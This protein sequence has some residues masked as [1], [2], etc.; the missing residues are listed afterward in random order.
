VARVALWLGASA[1]A[2]VVTAE[3][4]IHSV[5]YDQIVLEIRPL[6]AEA[7]VEDEADL[8]LEVSETAPT[9]VELHVL[10]PDPGR[11]SRLRLEATRRLSA[12]GQTVRIESELTPAG[13]GAATS[14]RKEIAF[15]SDTVTALFEVARDGDRVLTL[16]V[17]GELTHR[18]RY[19]AYPVVGA[20]VQFRV[21]VEWIEQGRAVTLET[22]RLNT[23]VGQS[24]GYSFRL[25]EIGEAEAASVRLLPVRLLGD[26]LRIEVEL[27]GML[28]DP[29]RGLVAVSRREQWLS[30]Q[31][32]TSELSLADG[33]PPT[34]FRFL[35]TPLF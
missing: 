22:N 17:E 18:R 16:A 25:G 1:C 34:G 33:D 14:A 11:P 20:P 8:T 7:L 6:T 19:A 29:E 30:T 2:A 21:D 3:P 5:E 32:T 28:P 4:A 13:G 10:W 12:T 15:T 27:S 23:F 31:G 9:V 26:T 35:V 24:V